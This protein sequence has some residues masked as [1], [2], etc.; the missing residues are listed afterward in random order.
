MGAGAETVL[1]WDWRAQPDLDALDR[2]VRAASD[3]LVGVTQVDTGGDQYA[4]VVACPPMTE[5]QAGEAWRASW[6][7]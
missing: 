3:G 2:A 5:G 1:S 6:G 4:I 7:T